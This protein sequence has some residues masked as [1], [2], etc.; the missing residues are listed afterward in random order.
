LTQREGIEEMTAWTVI[1]EIGPEVSKFATVKHFG[2]WLGLCPHVTKTGGRV[3]SSRTRPGVNRV[4]ATL[5]LAANGLHNSPGA[6]GAFLRRRKSRLG[7]SKAI[8]ATAHKIARQLYLALKHGM[9][10]V[11]QSQ[12]EYEQKHRER[13]VKSLPKKA[14]L[15]GFEV[16]ETKPAKA[17]VP[18]SAEPTMAKT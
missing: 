5:R 4:A 9:T 12:E 7:A 15:L 1:S 3:Q 10:Y 17:D 13:Q 8:T 18:E 6:H 14:K 11:R 16:V 2:S